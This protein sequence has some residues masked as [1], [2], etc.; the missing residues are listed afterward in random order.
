MSSA[1]FQPAFPSVKLKPLVHILVW[2][3][4]HIVSRLLSL[5]I[6]PQ[7]PCGGSMLLILSLVVTVTKPRLA[8]AID[9]TFCDYAG[10]TAV[11][12]TRQ[13]VM[14]CRV[15]QNSRYSFRP[16]AVGSICVLL[17][18]FDDGYGL[19]SSPGFSSA[20]ALRSIPSHITASCSLVI[21]IERSRLAR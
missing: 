10:V 2:L 17:G 1:S 8:G 15:N 21:A 5:W 18:S 13:S 9:S 14:A 3:S 7:P 20:S 4:R 16:S 11:R 12:P 19:A 6:T